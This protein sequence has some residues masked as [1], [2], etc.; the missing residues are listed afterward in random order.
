MIELKDG[1]DVRGLHSILWAMIYDIEPFY[2][3]QGLALTLTSA[4][5]GKHSKG[6]LHYSGLAVDIRTK[7]LS[8]P[9]DMYDRIKSVL[10]DAFDVVWHD[11]HIHI[12]YQPKSQN[13]RVHKY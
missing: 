4:L 11:T 6:S 3:E 7:T 8:E 2:A 1:T 9:K 12:E 10:A 13:E 5:D